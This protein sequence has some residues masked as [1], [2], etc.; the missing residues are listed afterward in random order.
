MVLNTRQVLKLSVLAGDV[1][2][3]VPTIG[4]WMLCC[5]S[6]SFSVA[7]CTDV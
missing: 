2:S 6:D 3:T 1:L 7:S 5:I 4:M